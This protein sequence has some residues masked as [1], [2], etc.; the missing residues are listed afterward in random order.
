MVISKLIFLKPEFLCKLNSKRRWLAAGLLLSLTTFNANAL[1]TAYTSGG[2]NLVYSSLGNITWTGDAN[3]LDTLE[4]SN[5]N[6][7]STII[8]TIGF[9]SDSLGVHTLTDE[10]FGTFGLVTWYGAQAY[11]EYLNNINYAG[12]NQWSLPSAGT[13][14]Q[15]GYSQ[16]GGQLGQLFYNELGGAAD[17]VIPYTGNFTNM[18]AADYW[19]TTEWGD[20]G[21][22]V[23]SDQI[24]VQYEN[25]KMNQFYAWA[26]SP[27]QVSAVPVPAAA[28]LFGPALLGLL[29]FK[30][31]STKG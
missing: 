16:T 17:V 7:V 23:F 29:G 12:S 10:D 9:I 20:E 24:G 19:Y 18:W 26:V 25:F 5:P 14:P 8:N 2:Q 27:G 31:R 21:A 30:R 22:W 28:W 6:L 13:D 11:I 1:T 4:A 15:N 3:L